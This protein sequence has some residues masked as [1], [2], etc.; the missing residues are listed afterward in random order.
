MLEDASQGILLDMIQKKYV[1][2]ALKSNRELKREY[3]ELSDYEE[4]KSLE[5]RE[6]VFVWAWACRT[7]PFLELDEE[8]RLVPCIEWAFPGK[9]QREAKMNDYANM[10]FPDHI[11]GAIRRME[12]FD[13]GLRVQMA[14]DNM[15]LLKQCQQAIRQDIKGADPE[16]IEDYMKTAA[17]AR[18]IMADIQKDIERGNLGVEESKNTMLQNLEGASAAFHKSRA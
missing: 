8:K 11:K 16:Q 5:N 17:L 15:H 7:S 13:P 14:A 18:K 1:I 4:F 6:L 12:R 9:Q 10:K 2:F 3:P